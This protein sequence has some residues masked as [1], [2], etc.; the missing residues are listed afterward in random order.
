[1]WG[2]AGNVLDPPRV[3]LLKDDACTHTPKV[4]VVVDAV[5]A[6]VLLVCL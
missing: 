6:A 4:V 2:L 1:M 5:V 3:M